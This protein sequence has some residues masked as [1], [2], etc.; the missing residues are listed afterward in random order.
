MVVR[1]KPLHHLQAWDINTALLVP[2][3]HG[4]VCIEFSELVCGIPLRDGTKHL[5]VVE[6]LVVVREVIAGNNVHSCVFLDLPVLKSESLA[7]CEEF[8]LGELVAPVRF[9]GLLQVTELAHA[10]EA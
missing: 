10:W 9:G 6:N 5:D 8:F 7:L 3:A 4:E 2:T 1:V